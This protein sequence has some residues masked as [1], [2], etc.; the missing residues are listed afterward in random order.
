MADETD[1]KKLSKE[2]LAQVQGGITLD[3][4]IKRQGAITLDNGI[5]QSA[6]TLDNGIKQ[7]GV[8]ADDLVVNAKKPRGRK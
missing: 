2:Q 7:T 3:N 1:P 8:I 5:K 6:I 4:G